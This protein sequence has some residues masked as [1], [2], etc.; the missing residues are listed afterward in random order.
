[1]CMVRNKRSLHV[2][3]GENLLK[4][5][6]IEVFD[7]KRGGTGFG[8]RILC[9]I[10]RTNFHHIRPKAFLRKSNDGP[11]S[12]LQRNNSDI[13]KIHWRLLKMF[14]SRTNEPISTKFHGRTWFKFWRTI[15]VFNCI[16]FLD[17]RATVMM[18]LIK[19]VYCL[20]LFFRWA[21]GLFFS[22]KKSLQ[23][24]DSSY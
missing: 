2:K 9:N 21:T 5:R 8:G 11:H 16:L 1:M 15:S 22:H 18:A 24:I 19:H 20:L 12:F 10:C 17:Q 6:L 4:S 13:P 7:C 3:K 23:F 14:F